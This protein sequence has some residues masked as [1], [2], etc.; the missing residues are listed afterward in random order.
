MPEEIQ[1]KRSRR[2]K[3][4]RR[5]GKSKECLLESDAKRLKGEEI[6]IANYQMYYQLEKHVFGS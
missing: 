4:I 2:K 3:N 6:T 5:K 1:W